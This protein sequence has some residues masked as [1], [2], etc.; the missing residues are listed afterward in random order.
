MGPCINEKQLETVMEYVEIGKNEGAKLLTGG[1]RL[2]GGA[3]RR[4]WFHEPTV[5]ADCDPKMRIA[6]EEIFGPV[7]AVMPIE[8]SRPSRSPT[9]W[10]TGFRLRSTRAT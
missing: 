10:S 8:S 6:Q 9:A 5:F 4:G 2:T 1:Q 3:V 7:V